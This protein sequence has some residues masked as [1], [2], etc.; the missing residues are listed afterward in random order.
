MMTACWKEDPSDRPTV[1]HVLG[2]LRGAAEQWEY[3]ERGRENQPATITSASPN[4]RRPAVIETPIPIPILPPSVLAP[5]A[6]ESEASP[7][8]SPAP[9]SKKQ[10]I[11]PVPYS[12]PKG[13]REPT[14]ASATQNEIEPTSVSPPKKQLKSTP[15]TLEVEVKPI[16]SNPSKGEEPK[17][18]TTT[19]KEEAP[20]Q[21][22]PLRS[23]R[24]E[25][26]PGPAP[27]PPAKTV[28]LAYG[29]A[30]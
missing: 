27:R 10:Q 6:V 12:S 3:K 19:S 8:P 26:G 23:T 20:K 9:S 4:S 25:G 22:A 2:V 16:P 13:E 21:K 17:R 28:T 24:E 7:K 5:S 1:G 18:T 15:A 30:R 11:S 29:G 14:P